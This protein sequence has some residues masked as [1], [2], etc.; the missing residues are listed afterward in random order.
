MVAGARYGYR[1]KVTRDG[2]TQTTAETW[3]EIPAV[4]R[5][6]LHGVRPNP[7]RGSFEVSFELPDAAPATLDVLDISGRRVESRGVGLLGAGSQAITLGGREP[8]PAGIYIVRLT[9]SGRSLATKACV[10]W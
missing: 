1:L 4:A 10:I 8:L 3:L 6:A 7:T 2:A 9:R 5:F